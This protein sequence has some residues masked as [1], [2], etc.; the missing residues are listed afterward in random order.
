MINELVTKLAE[1]KASEIELETEHAAV[2]MAVK[3]AKRLVNDLDQQIRESAKQER[4]A[5]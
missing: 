1:A 2:L 4:I 3:Q 5:R